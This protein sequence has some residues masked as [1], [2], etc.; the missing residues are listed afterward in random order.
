ATFRAYLVTDDRYPPKVSPPIKLED[1][2][3]RDR[4]GK[5]H[6]LVCENGPNPVMAVFVR[7]A[8]PKIT[9]LTQKL[10]GLI[11]TYR[12]D[13]LAAFAMFLRLD[14]EYPED[15]ERDVKA[16]DVRDLAAATKTSNVPFG[17]A[18]PKSATIDAWG[19]GEKDEYTIVFYR[20]M[21]QITRWPAG[22]DGPTADQVK[23]IAQT[24]EA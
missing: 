9:E 5:I 16:K 22:A 6:C 3:P 7:A 12:G 1:R 19:I 11:P 21:P 14:G 24:V 23:E 8:E 18:P 2:D 15:E 4:T 10:N 13:K 20:N 17:L